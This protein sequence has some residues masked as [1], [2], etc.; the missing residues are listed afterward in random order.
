V[1][2]VVSAAFNCICSSGKQCVVELSL[3]YAE[4]LA[5]LFV[6]RKVLLLGDDAFESLRE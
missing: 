3:V 4:A 6:V 1:R 5:I 2:C